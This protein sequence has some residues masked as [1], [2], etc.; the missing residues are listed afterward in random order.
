L[1]QRGGPG[2]VDV[3]TTLAFSSWRTAV[4]RGFAF[5][6]ERLALRLLEDGAVDRLIVAEPLRSVRGRARD[7]AIQRTFPSDDRTSL[8]APMQLAK[9]RGT[10]LEA[11]RRYDRKLLDAAD[12]AGMRAPRLIA[13]HPLHAAVADTTRWHQVT[14]YAWDDWSVH[15][16]HRELWT[17]YE[18]AYES[19]RARRLAVCAVTDQLLRTIA[20]TGPSMVVPNGIFPGEWAEEGPAPDWYEALPRPRFIYAGAVG[21][22]LDVDVLG[23][24]AA[25]FPHATVALVGPMSEPY[26][27]DALRSRS[28]VVFAPNQSR[29]AIRRILAASDVGIMPHITTPLTLAMSPLKVFE[30]IAAGLPAVVSD[31]PPVRGLHDRVSLADSADGFVEAARSALAMGPVERDAREQLFREHCWHRRFDE[32]LSVALGDTPIP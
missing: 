31:L 22:R 8:A 32:L 11:F 14:Y 13:S 27:F 24:L 23:R 1:T 5:P 3:V 26:H 15:H 18:R 9:P 17:A 2:A 25:A 30:Y 28:N 7:L 29:E 4:E 16:A 6:V 21:E 10:L 19:I 20:P 12:R